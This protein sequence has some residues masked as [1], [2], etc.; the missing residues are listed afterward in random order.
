MP[1]PH[2]ARVL[3]TGASGT[4]GYNIVRLLGESHPKTR[5][6]VLMR[7]PDETLFGDLPNVDLEHVDMADFE[8][9]ARAGRAGGRG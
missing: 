8:A 1:R 4:L 3:I 2:L 7:T 9:S 6:H 5:V